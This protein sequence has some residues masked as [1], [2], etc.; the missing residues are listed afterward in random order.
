M[1][2]IKEVAFMLMFKKHWLVGTRDQVFFFP[3]CLGDEAERM[4]D[5]FSL[6]NVC[7]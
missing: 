3:F 6:Y 4:S 1:L 5:T 7:Q 2:T